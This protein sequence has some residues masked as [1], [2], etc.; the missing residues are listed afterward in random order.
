METTLLKTPNGRFRV[1]K[2][3]GGENLVKRL[4]YMGIYEGGI[5]EKVLSYSKGPVIVK[6]LNSQIAIGRGMAEKI[7]VERVE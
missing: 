3:N 6:I 7:I 4:N 2:I 5:I 1:V